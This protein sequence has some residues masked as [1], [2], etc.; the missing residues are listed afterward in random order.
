MN[1]GNVCHRYGD[2]G[3]I[4]QNCINTLQN[5]HAQEE[6]REIDGYDEELVLLSHMEV[7]DHQE[8]GKIM[9]EMSLA[10]MEWSLHM[11][12]K[13]QNN[14]LDRD[15]ILLDSCSTTCVFGNGGK[16][17]LKNVQKMK[18]G[19]KIKCNGG[20][21]ETSIMVNFGSLLV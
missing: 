2:K 18:K 6:I 21:R 16:H 19:V 10:H 11:E 7:F 1:P 9:Y 14:P 12:G 20:M 3:H 17:L 8:G 5:T 15:C 4:V 13:E